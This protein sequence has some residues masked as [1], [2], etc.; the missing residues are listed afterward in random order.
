[1]KTKTPRTKKEVGADAAALARALCAIVEGGGRG[2]LS[3]VA[4]AVGMPV[5][6]FRKRLQRPGAGLDEASIK[7]L[8]FVAGSKAENYAE[9]PVI[10]SETVG[11]YVIEKRELRRATKDVEGEVVITWRLLPKD[12]L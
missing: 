5:S 8:V 7:C 3:L 1:M 10:S 12:N 2:T 11:R 9:F 6:P 4:E